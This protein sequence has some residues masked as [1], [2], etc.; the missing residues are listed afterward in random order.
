MVRAPG[1]RPVP[2]ELGLHRRQGRVA[3]D[4]VGGLLGHHH[5]R[6]VDVAV[7][8]VGHHRG[9]D[10]PQPAGAVHAHRERVDHR[11]R[12]GAH[13]GRAA[14][15][16][17]GLRVPGH[18]VEDLL[19]GLH[20]RAGGELPAVERPQGGLP[21]D[22]P[23]HLERL[24]PLPTVLVGGQVVEAQG[25]VCARVRAGDR[26]GAAGVGVHRTDVH[27]VAVFGRDRRA[28]VAHRDRQEVEHQVRVV[29][30]VVAA[31]EAARLEMVGRAGAAAQ[32]EP[33][34]TGARASAV[35]PG[36]AASTPAACTRAA[37]RPP[38]GPG[39]SRRRRAGR[40]P[41]GCPARAAAPGSPTPDSCSSCGVLIA[42]PHRT[43]SP[44][45]T[46]RT[47]LPQCEYSTPTA[48]VP[49]NAT[50][51]TRAP[52]RTS[53]LGR[54]ITGCRYARGR[55]Q[56]PP[57]VDVAVE[58]GEALLAVPVDVVGERVARLL[59]RLQEGAEQRVGGGPAFEHERPAVPAELVVGRGG[60]AVLHADEVGQAVGVVPGGHPG[61]G[62]PPLVV[63]RVAALEDHP[64][65]AAGAAEHLAPGVRDP[66][67]AHVRLRLGLVAPVVE[68][69]AA[70]ERQ[71]GGHV[72]E[73]VPR[74]VAAAR[75]QHEH[76]RG[77]VRRQP[78]GQRTAGRSAP[79]DDDVVPIA[80][81]AAPPFVAVV[82]R[83]RVLPRR[84][85]V[86]A[87][88]PGVKQ[89]RSDRSGRM[90]CLSSSSGTHSACHGR[91]SR[92]GRSCA[93]TAPSATSP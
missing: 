69:A 6:R 10:H 35:W 79:D 60:Q 8:D 48:R 84:S 41:R 75:L 71:R 25:G 53:R 68:P 40:R 14:R 4:D 21:E 44:A 12:A 20:L 77:R 88:S 34:C 16:Q 27:L 24:D 57:A 80:R 70:G 66:P 91:V 58:P 78:V 67:A 33:P 29:D 72:D 43:T 74:V 49:S 1:H 39:G 5:H 54:D 62:R 87:R 86:P 83:R 76:P 45:S 22:V 30:V 18:P 31:D 64:V 2:V 37:R 56:P 51:V 36:R 26:A 89:G 9:V 42:P 7:G 11:H 17:R 55:G 81:H 90:T 73:H 59:R 85:L 61:V 82:G 13:G 19:V 52:V 38:G 50:F 15:V 23:G 65:D 63:Q 46:R 47:G 93:S 32:E 28:V 92:A 3:E